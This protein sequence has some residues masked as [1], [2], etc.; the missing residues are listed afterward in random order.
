MA[1]F[2][3]INGALS[4]GTNIFVLQASIAA[5]HSS[6][7]DGI[8]KVWKCVSPQARE[9]WKWHFVAVADTWRTAD[10]L[11]GKFTAQLADFTLAKEEISVQVWACVLKN[12]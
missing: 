3:G 9:S 4:D 6:P 12:N 8:A 10:S 11:L 2:T 5:E 1:N 7:L